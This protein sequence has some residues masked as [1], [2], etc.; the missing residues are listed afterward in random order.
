MP[1]YSASLGPSSDGT[2]DRSGDLA[3]PPAPVDNVELQAWTGSRPKSCIADPSDATQTAVTSGCT[4]LAILRPAETSQLIAS[5]VD[6][7]HSARGLKIS[8]SAYGIVGRFAAIRLTDIRPNPTHDHVLFSARWS[9]DGNGDVLRSVTATIP[10]STRRLCVSASTE[11][12]KP[13]C[14]TG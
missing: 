10:N 6:P 2:V 12:V 9:P 13:L 14:K 8:A 11:D 7:K 3:L 1:L 4:E 5:W